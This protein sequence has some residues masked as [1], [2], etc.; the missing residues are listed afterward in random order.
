MPDDIDD[1]PWTVSDE[2]KLRFAGI[3][4]LEY[5]INHPRIFQLWL[6]DQDSDLEPILE[7]LLT[8]EW[9]Q[10][11][12]A[13]D[14]IPT[15]EG[16]DVIKRF[17]ERYARFVYFFDVF[18]G[19][20]LG[21]GE[22]AFE[23]YFE[24][25]EPDEW[26]AYL[27]DERFEDVRIAIAEHLG[28]DAVE[29]V[30]MSFIREDRFGRD[31]TGWQFDLLLGSVWDESLD[32]CNSATDV[33]ELGYPDGGRWIDGSVV[34]EDILQQGGKLLGKLLAQADS[35]IKGTGPSHGGG[36]E[37]ERVVAPVEF[38]PASDFN[39]ANYI[40]P[41]NRDRFWDDNWN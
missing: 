10:I 35:V 11:R 20:D 24:I 28:I 39:F 21:A 41:A 16:R 1:D 29:I 25:L 15:E 4:L 32:V 7:W 19:V 36:N 38:P 33:S 17:M 26:Q 6:E 22:F 18:S 12:E 2:Q 8:K 3:F 34:A 37:S 13:K 27:H 9:I 14:Y 30:F 31:A 23:R 5:M 40:E